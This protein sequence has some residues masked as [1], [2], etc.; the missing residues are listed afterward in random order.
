MG[1]AVVNKQDSVSEAVLHPGRDDGIEIADKLCGE[2]GLMSCGKDP[3]MLALKVRRCCCRIRT[4]E[5]VMQQN[6]VWVVNH[7]P[8]PRPKSS[9]VVRFFVICRLEYFVKAAQFFPKGPRSQQKRA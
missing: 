1:N 7:A 5:F 8:V 9:T 2:P 3:L 4:G 6:G